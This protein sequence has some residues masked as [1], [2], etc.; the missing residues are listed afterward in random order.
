MAQSI[1]TKLELFIRS[2]HLY[3]GIVISLSLVIPL[4]AFYLLDLMVLAPSFIFG[5]FLNAPNDIPGSLRRKVYGTLLS[6]ILTVLVTV[7][8]LYTQPF[9]HLNLFFIAVVTFGV[10][11]LSAYG[12]RA[13]LV[14]FSGLLAMVIA[15]ITTKTTSVDIWI[16]AAYMFCGGLWYLMASILFHK[17]VPK[18]DHDQLLSETLKLTGAYLDIRAQLL[19]SEENRDELIQKTFVFQAQINEKHETLRELLLSSRKKS[20]RSHFDEKRL[21]IFISLV[22]ILES[23]IANSWDYDKFDQIFGTQNKH[24]EKFSQLNSEMAIQLTLLADVIITHHKIPSK[25][26]IDNCLDAANNAIAEYISIHKLP[27]ARE[28]ALTLRN[29]LDFQKKISQEIQTIRHAVSNI[30]TNS[31]VTLKKTEAKRFLTLQEYKPNILF[32]HFTFQSVIFRHALRLTIAII[33][34][35]GLGE[36]FMIQNAYWIMLTVLLILR[37]NYGLTKARAQDRIIG[38]VLGGALAFGIV[39]LTQNAIIYGALAFVSLILAFALMQQNYRW[40]AFFITLNIVAVYFFIQP[41]A[42]AVIQYRIIDTIIGGLISFGAIYLL[43]PSWEALNV[44]TIITDAV[45]KNQNYLKATELFYKDKEQQQL[46]YK[47]ARKEAFLALSQLSAAFQRI[48]QDPKS[49]QKE[50]N[51]IYEI[52]TL[53]QTIL[54]AIASLGSFIHGHKTTPVSAET[55]A[56]FSKVNN[57]LSQIIAKL[58]EED[59]IETKSHGDISKAKEKLKESYLNLSQARDEKIKSGQVN[60]QEKELHELQEAHL[61]SN[62][63]TWLIGLS[64]NLNKAIQKYLNISLRN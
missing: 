55:Q 39:L 52:V 30:N 16:H 25:K 32:E 28:G 18:K 38:T 46:Q 62:Q 36:F 24:I 20:G 58:N 26:N 44:R 49:K 35:F 12:F 17:I 7:L 61:V 53:N 21:V 13:S 54:S 37:P 14:A 6:T 33:F 40:A 31:K 63:L 59:K 22:D 50:F 10:S 11:F 57:T 8:F 64:S 15:M 19:I 9:F 34:A 60:I 1:R 4:F 43:F 48:T 5:A 42:I 29:L 27:K 45:Q 47:V 3:R 56:L 41:D 23:V 2:S 51:L